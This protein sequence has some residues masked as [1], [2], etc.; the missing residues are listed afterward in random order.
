MT[1]LFKVISFFLLGSLCSAA[2]VSI[3]DHSFEA[4]AGGNLA[5]GAWSNDLSPE[6]DENG[7]P[8][9]ANGFEEYIAGFSAEGT[10]HL[11]AG[12]GHA[13]WQDLG[14]TYQANTT[15]TLTISA[16]HRSGQ[17]ASGNQT[18]YSLR[19]P[20]NTIYATGSYDASQVPGGTFS[21]APDLVLDTSVNPAAVGQTIRIHLLAGGSGRSHFDNIRLDA[22]TNEPDGSAT[23]TNATAT[24]ITNSS[25]TLGGSVTDIGDGAPSVTIYYGTADGGTDPGAWDASINLP[26]TQSGNFSANVSSLS[27]ATTYY[28]TARAA[29]TGG[30]SWA[31]PSLSFETLA[32][33]A[34]I[35]QG[36]AINVTADSASLPATVTDT[37]GDNPVVTVFYGTSDG[38]SNSGSWDSSES[39]G[40]I[41]GSAT[42]ELG[43]LAPATTYFFRF[44]AV[45]E[46]GISWTGGTSSFTTTSVTAP[47]IEN[48]SVG[49]LTA[50]SAALRGDVTETGSQDPT[51]TLYYGTSDGG[52]IPGNWDSSIAV[53]TEDGNYSRFVSDLTPNTTYFYTASATNSAGTSWAPTPESFT[54][55]DSLAAQVVI[56]EIH[57]DPNDET[58]AEEFIELYNPGT[59]ALDLSGWMITDAV[60]FTFPGGTVIPANGYLVIAEDPATMNSVY[61][62][63]A[64][65]PWTGGLRNTGEEI[66]LRDASGALQDQVDYD[67]GFPWP[68]GARGG[69]GSMELLNAGL[70]NNLGGSWRTSGTTIDVGP[71]PTTTYIAASDSNWRYRKGTSEASS[72][73]TEWRTIEF[74]EDASWITGQT[75]VGFGD[76][77]D[78]TLLSDMRSNYST[79]YLRHEFTVDPLEI[80][81]NLKLRIY[82]DDGA[83]VWINGQEVERVHV[84]AGQKAYNDTGQN[85]E[86][87]WEEFIIGGANTF[88]VGGTN[89]IAVHALNA[90][91]GSSDFSIDVTLEATNESSGGG[92]TPTPGAPN[93]S[94]SS[95][96]PPAIRQ[97]DHSPESPTSTDP[98]TIT[99]KLTD[100][101]GMGAVTLD[102]QIVNPG[103]YIRIQDAAYDSS[104]TTVNMYDDGT[105]G[106]LFSG[107]SIYTAVLPASVQSHRR[108]V[109]YRIHF[110]DNNGTGDTAPYSDDQ[111]PN[112]AYFVYD[113]V[114]SW[115]G[116]FTPTSADETFPSTVMDSLPTYHL[117]A[118][119]T[120][121]INSQYNGGSDGVHMSGTIVYNGRVYDHIEFENRGE[122]STYVAGKNKWR[123]HFN[124]ARRFRPLDNWGEPYDST[125]TRI[126]VQSISSPWAAVNRGM[127]GLDESLTM[128]MYELA[129]IPSPRTHYFSFRVIDDAQEAD[130]GDQFEGDVWGLYLA[131]ESPN[132]SFLDDRGLADGNIYK[133]EGGNGDKK[134]QGD[135][136]VTN[137]SDWSSFYS[138][139]NSAQTEQWWRDNMY[140]PGYYSMRAL[141]RILGNVDIRFGYN[142]YFYHEPTQDQWHVMPWDLDMM[143]IAETH[144]AGV[145]RQQNSILNHSQLMLEFRNRAREILDLVGE[146]GS[147]T[148]GQIGQLI[149]EYTDMINPEGDAQTW[150]DIDA[151]MWNYHPRTRGTPGNAS[152]QS[153]HKGNFFAS[154]YRDSRIGGSYTRTLTSEDHEGLVNHILSYTTD[155]FTGGSWSPGNGIVPGYGYE[156]L[157]YEARDT[158]IPNKPSITYGGPA[159]YPV[160]QLFF[161]SSSFSDPNGNNSFGKMRWRIAKILAPG[162]PGYV[163]NTPRTYEIETVAMSPDFDTFTADYLFPADASE[164]G[165]TYRVRVQHEDST[166]RTSHWSDPIEFVTGVPNIDLWQDNLVISEIMYNP[167]QPNGSELAVSNDNDD[168]EFLEITNISDSLT[169]DLTDLDFTNGI[170]FDF[171]TA[172]S[173][174]IAPGASVLLVKNQ[175]AFEARYGNSLPVIGTYPN[176]LSN[177]GERLALSFALNTPIIDF[178]Y[179]DNAPWPTSPDG[180]GYSLVLVDP[181]SGPDHS[182][183]SSWTA[184]NV[185]GGTPGA[186][187]PDLTGLDGYLAG[188]FS[189]AEM[190]D[191]AISGPLADP[192]KDG[193]SNILEYA[194]L[195]DPTM[196]DALVDHGT[197][198]EGGMTYPSLTFLQ[199]IP[200]TDLTYAPQQ[201]TDLAG[202][203]EGAAH[204]VEHSAIDQGDGTYLVT[205]RSLTP[206]SGAEKQFLRIRVIHSAP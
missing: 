35:T 78:N 174:T 204:L 201:S 114:P 106:D 164:P 30:T 103:S 44:R 4:N 155:N 68:T 123:I 148:G 154:P 82:A 72:P 1:T 65:G 141:N 38:G 147:P 152:G 94:S 142:H 168:F 12:P 161:S 73:V 58:S 116:S 133:I 131:M 13:I 63:T 26:G 109:R 7:G 196:D 75:P 11:G 163:D 28:F 172:T 184:G 93:T 206:V 42:A 39:L 126:N 192:D 9:S 90:T 5:S 84:T 113:G 125:W 194:L 188:F 159:G 2:P 185:I 134:E 153:N 74:T 66:D 57:Y 170:T 175:A 124:R 27:N 144:Q 91:L 15:Y 104:W 178:V 83:I 76:G 20:G 32:N 47:T 149:D 156:Y 202:W 171:S 195:G 145:I 130:P 150:A 102:Y 117:I 183:A 41:S 8:S 167:P 132:G 10:D 165:V 111:Q 193:Y 89:V 70:D 176:S 53:G 182:L 100:P 33:P 79:V 55:P 177:G 198:D 60:E 24:S 151:F 92:T 23:L 77:D 107:D 180:G 166:G 199:R 136:Q 191:P 101:D 99:A 162:L 61:G 97:V 190:A 81:Q 143:Y 71:G 95:L 17:T 197:V 200:S 139:S 64:L 115:T 18:T 120:D 86:A 181:S 135:T 52:T 186:P 46:G 49:S 6:W 121:V 96:T 21:D 80:P 119:N 138:A 48:R 140:M 16:G 54:T 88:L 112:F 40:T 62:I 118:N 129:G 98:V 29:N 158:S 3:G 22:T 45:N 43:G 137:S 189:P 157:K 87:E 50:F 105:N 85:H 127:A 146:D 173:T 108:L 19:N 67:D 110:E 203:N 36:S 187:E 160:N 169:I 128:R 122:A 56:N 31:S 51:V 37:G 14:D 25:A 69:G 205:V 59:T 34:S 179:D